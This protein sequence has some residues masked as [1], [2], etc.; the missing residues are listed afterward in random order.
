VDTTSNFSKMHNKGYYPLYKGWELRYS[1]NYSTGPW[2]IAHCTKVSTLQ[3]GLDSSY[4]SYKF[5][6]LSCI[7]IDFPILPIFC[8][9]SRTFSGIYQLYSLFRINI[10]L[11]A[12]SSSCFQ[13]RMYNTRN[14]FKKIF[15]PSLLYYEILRSHVLD[16]IYSI[17]CLR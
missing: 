5:F 4:I 6:N 13:C 17:R 14:C 16:T 11:Q 15:F 2:K 8:L 10:A 1:K 12:K 3:L 7:F 9:K